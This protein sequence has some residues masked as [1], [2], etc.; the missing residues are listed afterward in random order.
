MID[1]HGGGTGWRGAVFVGVLGPVAFYGA[2]LWEHA[3]STGA[4][5]LGTA[6]LLSRTDRWTGLLGGALWGIAVSFRLEAGI[7]AVALGL[8][9]L[10]TPALRLFLMRAKIRAALFTVA[11]VSVFV[12]DRLLEQLVLASAVR[13]DRVVGPGPSGGGLAGQ[14]GSDLGQRVRD[15]LVTNVGIIANDRDI[16]G[17][18]LGTLYLAA[19]VVLS[20]GVTG[21]RLPRWI[22]VLSIVWVVI[23]S[24]MIAVD[25]S[26]V[27]GM[28]VAAP[29]A[30]LG[31]VC[32][33]ARGPSS[34]VPLALGRAGLLSLPLIWAFQWT[35]SLSAQWG[36]RY[37]L[38]VAA[39]LTLSGLPAM[40][41]TR[42][43]SAALTLVGASVVVGLVAMVWHVERT[44]DIGPVFA[45][46]ASVE[47]PG[48][49][50]VSTHEFLIREGGGTG[51]VQEQ[52]L[53]NC[54]LLS[55]TPAGAIDALDVALE[56]GREAATILYAGSVDRSRL[57][58]D[59]WDIDS[60]EL[61][62]AG[63]IPLTV[64]QV[65]RQE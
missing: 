12:V 29:L 58:L 61:L 35:G 51:P 33:S 26:F 43:R 30:A 46:L 17:F 3:P 16:G 9:I 1:R 59:H 21:R 57:E 19:L 56:T 52:R 14:V 13:N 8:V 62:D 60:V 25:P 32:A 5:V 37:Q 64:V 10:F 45:E 4:A 34:S 6:C 50:I 47:C 36:G 54:R 55:T 27:P 42:D 18:V 24:L 53:G 48:Q 65:S 22:R 2:D 7:V 49:L 41:N 31:A 23:V 28:F 44:N 63:R 20:I 38:T 15:V 39:F 11:A 40:R